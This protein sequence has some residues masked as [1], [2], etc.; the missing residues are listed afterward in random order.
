[1]DIL[2]AARA[3]D[4][5]HPENRVTAHLRIDNLIINYQAFSVDNIDKVPDFVRSAVDEESKRKTTICIQTIELTIFFTKESPL[6]NFYPSLL[7][8]DDHQYDYVEH[9]LAYKKYLL[10]SEPELAQEILNT[11]EPRDQKRMV[12]SLP[13]YNPGK[14]KQHVTV[15][16][17]PALKA[18]FGQNEHLK[19]SLLTTG[20]RL[21][22]ESSPSDSMFGIGLSLNNS[23]AIVKTSWTGENIQG[24]TL[25]EVRELLK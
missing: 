9:Y 18:K 8:M 11:S 21:I 20:N 16:F 3:G 19:A 22:R 17:K 15:I 13:H 2:G 6:F 4:P 1:M 23:A 5:N 14:W 25:M 12:R 24:F 7:N 10:F